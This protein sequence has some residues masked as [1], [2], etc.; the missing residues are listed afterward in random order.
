MYLK[1]LP[2]AEHE[3]I[4]ER[5]MPLKKSIT[6]ASA[7][8][9]G[10]PKCL[11]AVLQVL[12]GDEDFQ[13]FAELKEQIDDQERSN[14]ILRREGYHHELATQFTPLLIKQLRPQVPG[15]CLNF[16]PAL[17]QFAGYYKKPLAAK[18]SEAP[19][20]KSKARTKH[21]STAR[22]YGGKWTQFQ[23]LYLV[24]MQL[25]A[26]HKSHGGVTCLHQALPEI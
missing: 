21:H 26:W 14:I 10:S 16:Q 5:L 3:R 8:A 6:P 1:D 20:K 12:Y 9:K 7:A 13:K 11:G 17:S 25:W 15:C 4:L 18:G 23:A 24:V 2:A 19:T 22:V